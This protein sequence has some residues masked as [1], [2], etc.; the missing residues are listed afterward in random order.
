MPAEDFEKMLE[1]K[2]FKKVSVSTEHDAYYSRNDVDFLE[3]IECLRIRRRDDFAEI[4]YKPATGAS[5]S[6]GNGIIAKKETNVILADPEQAAVATEL[7]G[8]IGIVKLA[9]VIKSRRTF[10]SA[11]YPNVIIALDTVEQAGIF[12]EIEVMA[13]DVEAGRSRILE[14]EELLGVT[15]MPLV[16]K[17]YRDL[18]LEHSDDKA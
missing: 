7:F 18:V 6:I 1:D 13:P 12:I 3:T 11:D 16:T 10:K 14:L 17:P 4:T 9:D 2:G 5:T 8:N 15:D